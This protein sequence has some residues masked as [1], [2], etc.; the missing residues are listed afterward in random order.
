MS[1]HHIKKKKKGKFKE[2]IQKYKTVKV[3]HKQ[4]VV[5]WK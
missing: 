1:E 2:L 3:K 4:E 5:Q